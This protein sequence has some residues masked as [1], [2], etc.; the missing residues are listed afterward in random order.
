MATYLQPEINTF[1]ILQPSKPKKKKVYSL[2]KPTRT[3]GLKSIFIPI[4]NGICTNN[5]KR[6]IDERKRKNEERI[7]VVKNSGFLYNF[8]G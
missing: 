5:T 3:G 1:P 2:D 7:P 6:I 8:F 4:S